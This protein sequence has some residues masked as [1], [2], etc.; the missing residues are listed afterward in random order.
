MPTITVKNIPMDLY[1]HLKQS[2]GL[3]HRSI[4]SEIIVCIEQVLHSQRVLPETVLIRAQQLREKTRKH[5][6]TEAVL[7][8]AKMAGR[9]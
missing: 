2:A 7:T 8:K 3:N 1:T 6:I 5:P 9:R 4:N